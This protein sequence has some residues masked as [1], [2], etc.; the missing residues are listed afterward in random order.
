VWLNIEKTSE[1]FGK[2]FE[3]IANHY[4]TLSPRELQ[5]ASLIKARMPSWK[6][7]EMLFITE[8]AVEKHRSEIRRKLHLPHEA[9]LLTYLFR[10]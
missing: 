5:V 9:N 8:H 3:V 1:M 7:A 10:L 6:I 2:N 4:P